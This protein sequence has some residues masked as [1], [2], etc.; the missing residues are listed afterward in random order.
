MYLV[1]PAILITECNVNGVMITAQA[2]DIP[3]K[4]SAT[5]SQNKSEGKWME[6]LV[7]W[8]SPHDCVGDRGSRAELRTALV[9][10]KSML[11]LT[12][13]IILGGSLRSQGED[14][15][16]LVVPP[17]RRVL[18]W[19]R[20]WR[21]EQYVL[22][23]SIVKKEEEQVQ[24]ANEVVLP[25]NATL[26]RVRFVGFESQ[27]MYQSDILS[28]TCSLALPWC[29]GCWFGCLGEPN[30]TSPPPSDAGWLSMGRFSHLWCTILGVDLLGQVVGLLSCSEGREGHEGQTLWVH[31]CP[32]KYT[33]IY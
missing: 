22:G 4:P 8:P 11:C 24:L 30:R 31:G 27:I 2:W 15:W 19:C 23:N 10:Y 21:W 6:A 13:C 20:A 5:N 18:M 3:K 33:K 26:V 9:N 17:V 25:L 16:C 32:S 14:C 7:M 1:T 12:S 28:S 29:S